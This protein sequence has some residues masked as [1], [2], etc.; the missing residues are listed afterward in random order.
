MGLTDAGALAIQP[1]EQAAYPTAGV[2]GVLLLVVEAGVERLKL[3]FDR[4]HSIEL[5][6]GYFF[7]EREPARR[8]REIWL[9]VAQR[10]PGRSGARGS[11]VLEVFERGLLRIRQI[12]PLRQAIHTAAGRGLRAAHPLDHLGGE[13]GVLR[14]SRRRRQG[15]AHEGRQDNKAHRTLLCWRG[16]APIAVTMSAWDRPA[17]RL[18]D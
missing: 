14:E 2:D 10:R 7:A 5:R 17:D 3:G 8:R 18:P 16:A 15:E 4:L 1:T 6:L 12:E 13:P 11:S 9:H